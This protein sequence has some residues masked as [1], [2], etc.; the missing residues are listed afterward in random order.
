MENILKN[1][2]VNGFISPF[3]KSYNIHEAYPLHLNMRT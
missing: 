2:Q 1:Q 3:S